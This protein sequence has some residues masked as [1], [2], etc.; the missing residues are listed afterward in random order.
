MG[1]MRRRRHREEG[2]LII[3][4]LGWGEIQSSKALLENQ[5]NTSIDI[6][7]DK[8]VT[9]AKTLCEVSLHPQTGDV[10]P[11]IFRPPALMPMVTPMAVAT[12]LPHIGTKPAFFWQFLFQS[13][14]AGFNWNHRNRTCTVGNSQ[15]IPPIISLGS[16]TYLS[17]LGA[18][19]QFL[20]NR[21]KF[22]SSASQ[23]FLMRILPVPL[24]TFLSALNVITM[25]VQ[26]MESGVEVK[27]KSGRVIGTSSRAGQ[28]AVKETAVSRAMLMGITALT[29]SA[30]HLLLKRSSF[31]VR[32]PMALAPIKH[33]AAALAFGSMIPVSF[34]LFPQQGTIHRSDL[35]K[36]LQ[37][38]TSES[39][40]FYH[41]GL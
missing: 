38:V 26:E 5:A 36:E 40:L 21:Y 8:K 3:I 15:S 12:L 29:P 22:T 16:V 24:I 14:C 4:Q 20:M 19:P 9:D 27:D 17:V 13:Y 7:Q 32:N 10:I 28:K 39:E 31:I 6:G 35:E 25:R 2:I 23:T 18:L 37:G 1:S 34:A 30:L 33:M 41:R 11:L